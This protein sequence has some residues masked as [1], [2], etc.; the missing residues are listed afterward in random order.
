MGVIMANTTVGRL[1]KTAI[2]TAKFKS[3]ADIKERLPRFFS[4]F[5]KTN[6]SRFASPKTQTVFSRAASRPSWTYSR[7][8]HYFLVPF[9][10]GARTPRIT[11]TIPLLLLQSAAS[12]SPPLL[13]RHWYAD[14]ADNDIHCLRYSLLWCGEG[15]AVGHLCAHA[16]FGEG[17]VRFK[18]VAISPLQSP[19][20]T[21]RTLVTK[22]QN[23]C[24]RCLILNI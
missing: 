20:N 2:N 18:P 1:A 3:V 12:T 17:T 24:N 19:P 22:G 8:P 16:D 21:G 14:S 10:F 4:C 11:P 13:A 15:T 5:F 9:F 6:L 23:T 7:H